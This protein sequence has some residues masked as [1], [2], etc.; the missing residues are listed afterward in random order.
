MITPSKN[1]KPGGGSGRSIKDRMAAFQSINNDNGNGAPPG[2]QTAKKLSAGNV[3]GGKKTTTTT[4]ASTPPIARKFRAKVGKENADEEPTSSSPK[5]SAVKKWKPAVASKK[6]DEGG[7]E[8]SGEES[9]SSSPKKVAKKVV[10]P[11]ASK[12]ENKKRE[13]PKGNGDISLSPK[14]ASPKKKVVKKV[15][16]KVKPKADV[17][18][19]DAGATTKAPVKKTT[20]FKP[21]TKVSTGSSSP[22]RSKSKTFGRGGGNLVEERSVALKKTASPT[23]ASKGTISGRKPL[24]ATPKPAPKSPSKKSSP[25]PMKRSGAV[26]SIEERTFAFKAA[27]ESSATPSWASKKKETKTQAVKKFRAPAAAKLGGR[28]STTNSPSKKKKSFAGNKAPARRSTTSTSSKKFGGTSFKP[29]NDRNSDNPTLSAPPPR[30][31]LNLLDK[32]NNA[33]DAPSRTDATAALLTDQSKASKTKEYVERIHAAGGFPAAR[34]LSVRDNDLVATFSRIATNDPSVDKSIVIDG[35]PRFEHLPQSLVI[36]AAEALRS[37]FYVTDLT[38][39]NVGLGNGFLSAVATSLESNFVLKTL[40]LSGNSFTNDALLEFAQAMGANTT[41]TSA[42]LTKQ[43]SPIF[44]N[45]QDHFMEALECNTTISSFDVD[46]KTETT[47]GKSADGK[48]RVQG[49]LKKNQDGSSRDSSRSKDIDGRLLDFLR[50]ETDRTEE[51]YEQRRAEEEILVVKDDDWNYLFDL[52]QRFDKYKLEDD[53]LNEE[54][55][56]DAKCM[57]KKKKRVES[58]NDQDV[59]ESDAASVVPLT[60]DGAFLTEEFISKYL[61]TAESGSLTFDFRN[62]FRVFKRFP[63][64]DPARQ[65]IV[66][67]FVSTLLAH[68]KMKDITNINMAN[69]CCGNDFLEVLTEKCLGNKAML[70]NLYGVNFETNYVTETGVVALAKCIGSDSTFPYLQVVRLENQRY[71]LSS[72]AELKLAKA[73]YINRGIIRLSLRVRNLLE[74]QQIQRYTQRNVDF[75]RQARRHRAAADG[76]LQERKRNAMEQLFDKI[77]ANDPGVTKVEIVG[78]QRFLSLN[79]EEKVKG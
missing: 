72:K 49:W 22:V 20:T 70:P 18:D 13:G 14:T 39:R 11:A 25:L 3:A 32:K 75:M 19:V 47:K 66:R 68:P 77:A 29:T 9:A 4:K 41:L 56:D 51:L 21:K 40:D 50:N 33:N 30:K 73:M 42:D 1:A 35:D 52:S 57:K 43:H 27:S 31:S 12:D 48:K 38:I 74:R 10:K 44:A 46:F 45:A 34:R 17:G 24:K 53:D 78:D 58:I 76:T 60:A 36:E 61:Q 64:T 28:P 65:R 67:T 2:F 69:T 54:D 63:V 37:N 23:K 8:R 59:G 62:Q 26:S 16:K 55:G 71:L 7:D 79:V 6:K 5:K 15:A